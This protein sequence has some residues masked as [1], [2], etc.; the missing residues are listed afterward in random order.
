MTNTG[1][2]ARKLVELGKADPRITAITAA[3]G[4]GTGVSAFAAEFPDRAFDVGIAEEHAVTFAAG[5]A[6]SGL[7]PVVAIYS[8]FL[9]RAYD[10]ILHD[11]CLQKL[12]VIFAID[13]SGLV[14]ADGDT[15]QGIFDTAFLSHIPNMTIIAPKNRYEL[16]RAM[17]WAVAYD[18]PVALKYSRGEAYYGLKEYNA[19][20]EYGRS[21][22]IHRGQKLAIVA[23]GN[24]VQSG[25]SS[26]LPLF[27]STK[28][29]QQ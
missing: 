15:H 25:F 13:R 2:F 17:E 26:I 4:K 5:L 3:M 1:V 27:A 29:N 24:M 18:G 20:I 22:M 6:A 21:E 28:P 9:Q 10:Q 16:T 14:G 23:V 19:D 11:V 8:S 12:H 7:V